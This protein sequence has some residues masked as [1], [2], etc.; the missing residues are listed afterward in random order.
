MGLFSW[1]L[2][3]SGHSLYMESMRDGETMLFLGDSLSEGGWSHDP[4]GIGSA[5][6]GAAKRLCRKLGGPELIWINRAQGGARSTEVLEQWTAW[7]EAPPEALTVLVGAND[8]WRR[9]VPWLDH[10]PIP[11]EDYG[12][13]LAKLLYAA[14]ERGVTELFV[15]TPT[16]LSETPDHPWNG[17]L[18]DYRGWCREIADACGAILVPTGEEWLAAVRAH[19]EV[20]WSYDGVHPRPIGHARLAR[21]WLHHALGL[22]PLPV[23]ELPDL[24]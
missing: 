22:A 6:P 3:G 11:P 21:T 18:E 12:R 9:F 8:L 23:T 15:C 5:W 14:Q 10:A 4:E 17:L 2:A 19:P 1:L 24:S 7:K 20:R 13:N 16:A